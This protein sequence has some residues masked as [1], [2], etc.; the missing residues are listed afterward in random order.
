MLLSTQT[1]VA[2]SELNLSSTQPLTRMQLW[3]DACPERE[4]P[5]V[6]KINLSGDKQ[7]LIAT[8]DGSNESLQLRQQV[9][10]HHIEL[11]KGEQASFQLHGP[12]AYLQS[13]HGTVHA[14]THTEEK[15]ALTCGDGAFIRDEANITLVADTPLRALLI[16]LPV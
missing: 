5:L 7:Q 15:E 11:K 12:R 13:I 16:D 2:Y 10:L 8:P 14:L 1:N 9:W 6:Q 3:L 4:N